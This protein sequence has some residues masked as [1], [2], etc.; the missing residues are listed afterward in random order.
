MDN[1][2]EDWGI[3]EDDELECD[4]EEDNDVTTKKLFV[5]R[6]SFLLRQLQSRPLSPKKLLLVNMPQK[7]SAMD[8]VTEAISPGGD[9]LKQ[10]A[11]LRPISLELLE[12]VNQTPS[13]PASSQPAASGVQPWRSLH[14]PPVSFPSVNRNW[15]SVIPNSSSPSNCGSPMPR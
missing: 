7:G 10:Q 5:N 12:T 11:H 2:D 1:L 4:V 3:T 8:E 9:I 14:S 6:P 13:P 15:M